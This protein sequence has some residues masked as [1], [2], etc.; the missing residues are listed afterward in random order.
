MLEG[1]EEPVSSVA[2]SPDGRTLASAGRPYSVD[3]MVEPSMARLSC[4]T[5]APG[6]RC[7][8]LMG[9]SHTVGCVAFSP[10]GDLLAS[11]GGW[12]DDTVILWNTRT[13]E[14]DQILEGHTEGVRLNNFL[15][16]RGLSWQPRARGSIRLW[17]VPALGSIYVR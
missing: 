7:G 3:P 17:D 12:Y 16:R 9:H 13:G 15:A 1:H 5:H 10:N 8:H 4:G 11:G 14:K 6:N 2:F